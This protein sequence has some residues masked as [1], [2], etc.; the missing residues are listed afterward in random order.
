MSSPPFISLFAAKWL[1][2]F[3]VAS[4]SGIG[5]DGLPHLIAYNTQEAVD[6]VRNKFQLTPARD[7]RAFLASLFLVCHL[8]LLMI[9]VLNI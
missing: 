3:L 4:L 1:A 9:Q 2:E 6:D 7:P 8:P 5:D